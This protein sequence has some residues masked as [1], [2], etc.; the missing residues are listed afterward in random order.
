MIARTVLALALAVSSVCAC[1][2]SRS[3]A[4]SQP[5]QPAPAMTGSAAPARSA[6]EPA[7][8]AAQAVPPLAPSPMGSG[9]S[10]GGASVDDNGGQVRAGTAN[11]FDEHGRVAENNGHEI[12]CQSDHDCACGL[13]RASGACAFGP[14]ARIDTTRQ[15]PDFCGGISGAMRVACDRGRCVQR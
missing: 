4:P 12:E 2:C 8:P 15:C 10:A 11:P 5:Q 13:D 3:A 6:G 9:S 1:A 14:V 7:A